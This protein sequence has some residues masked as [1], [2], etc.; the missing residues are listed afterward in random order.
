[1]KRN[2]IIMT[3]VTAA[4]FGITSCVNN[5]YD[6]SDL[7]TNIGVSVKDLSLPIQMDAIKLDAILDIDDDDENIKKMVDPN[8][9]ET[10]YAVVKSG[11]FESDEIKLDPISV[12]GQQFDPMMISAMLKSFAPSAVRGKK[13]PAKY[14]F[15]YD[16]TDANIDLNKYEGD[17]D[18]DKIDIDGIK[19]LEVDFTVKTTLDI[20]TQLAG[21]VD[22]AMLENVAIKLIDGLEDTPVFDGYVQVGPVKIEQKGMTS[23]LKIDTPIALNPSSKEKTE[24]TL[25]VDRLY[26]DAIRKFVEVAELELKKNPARKVSAS[27]GTKHFVYNAKIDFVDGFVGLN[28]EDLAENVT[29]EELPAQ[30]NIPAQPETTGIQVNSFSGL[31][32]YDLSDKIDVPDVNLNDLPDFL[33]EEGTEIKLQNPQLYLRINNPVQDGLN[34][35]VHAQTGFTFDNHQSAPIDIDVLNA[36]QKQNVYCIST[37]A[38]DNMYEGYEGAEK[39]VCPELGN[40]LSTGGKGLPTTISIKTNDAKV[41]G[42]V[43]DISLKKT[44]GKATGEYL[45]YVPLALGAGSKIS[46]STVADGWYS[47]DI[48]DLLISNMTVKAKV[49]TDVPMELELTAFPINTKG[50]HMKNLK[51]TCTVPANA[52]KQDLNLE[53]KGDIKDLDGID[54]KITLKAN[55]NGK[56]LSPDMNIMLEGIRAVVSGSYSTEL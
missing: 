51:A 47:D 6:L 24:I 45:F 21:K 39:I 38:L 55:Q 44:Y 1:M 41:E 3:L 13:A 56:T 36:D 43:T 11:S 10:I 37:T 7:D 14:S 26:G 9:N 19:D 28:E 40:I 23:L 35:T 5:D 16:L 46:Y 30:L 2:A 42:D 25:H 54:F 12:D 22:K 29:V 53:L 50:E 32:T 34:K 33:T 15:Y 27:K 52:N 31:V 4:T 17:I 48:K 18:L 8:T 20:A 49:S